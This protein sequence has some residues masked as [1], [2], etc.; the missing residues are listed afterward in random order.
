MAALLLG[1]A[2]GC[3]GSS[4]GLLSTGA[5][6]TGGAA[7]GAGGAAPTSCKTSLDC[8]ADH[9]CDPASSSCVQCLGNNDCHTGDLCGGDHVCHRACVTDKQCT[10]LGQLC[11]KAHGWCTS[12]GSTLDGGA[13]GSGGTSST[14][15]SG[16]QGAGGATGGS[17]GT[18][19]G[20][21]DAGCTKK[22]LD[23]MVL[24]DRSGSMTTDNRWTA[25]QKGLSVLSTSGAAGAGLQFL[26]LVGSGT[27]PSSCQTDPDCGNF[28]PCFGGT[29]IGDGSSCTVA[30]YATPAVGI[31]ALPA[32]MTQI[33][34]SLAGTSPNGNT[35]MQ[36]ALT[37]TLDYAQSFAKSHTSQSVTVLM[38]TDGEPTGCTGNDINTVSAAAAAAY[39]G[40]PS[41]KTWVMGIGTV[42]NLDM[43][44]QAGGT[45]NAFVG[46]STDP[47]TALDAAVAAIVADVPCQ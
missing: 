24:L 47:T 6:G 35:P 4:N 25:L 5:A 1:A 26:P 14:G 23:I 2:A 31:A 40:T 3:G 27:A 11:D 7:G 34:A 10:P 45:Q 29:C 18:G 33:N 44:A 9:V 16:G 22:P 37:G 42:A 8:P 43:V 39:N 19:T 41:I 30:D 17:G 13:G 38:I 28:A 15:G 46:T 20:G 32:V 21:S 36:P 12:T